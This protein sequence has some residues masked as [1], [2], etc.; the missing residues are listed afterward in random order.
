MCGRFSGEKR[1]SMPANIA[2]SEAGIRV[3][4]AG[5]ELHTERAPWY[6]ADSEF[7]ARRDYILLRAAPQHR[8]FVLHS[9]YRQSGVSAT[10][11]VQP[12]LG[13]APVQNLA[14]CH[15]ILNRAGDI[16][17]RYLRID[18]VLVEEVDAVSAG[19]A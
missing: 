17:D 15:Q 8:V 1:D 10:Q 12:H 18:A 3:N 11:R 16:L 9:G 13:Q 2:G 7:V 4:P 6:E 5:E 14:L 19:A